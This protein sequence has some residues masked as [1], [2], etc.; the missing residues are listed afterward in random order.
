M[1]TSKLKG[2]WEK[3]KDFFKNMSKKL[4]IILAAALAVILIAVIVLSVV[5]SGNKTYTQLYQD[6]TPTEASEIMT[7]FQNNGITDYQM[8]GSTI[9]VRN[10]QYAALLAQLAQAGYPKDASLYGSYYEHVGALSTSSQEART[11]QISTQERLE[12]SI[13]TF[14]NVLNAQVFINPGEERTYVLEDIS[15]ETTASVKVDMRSGTMLTDEQAD[16]IRRLVSHAWSGMSIDSVEIIDG[17]GNTYTSTE[18]S[19]KDAAELQQRMQERTNNQ[20]RDRK[21]VV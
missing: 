4:R 11:W 20:L 15:T 2:L 6:L 17:V 19:P 8:N 9:L 13:R 5:L 3:V 10:D 21:S 16:G 1:D 14:P 12:A 18:D 7:Y